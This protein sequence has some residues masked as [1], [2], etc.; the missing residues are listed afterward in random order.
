[1]CIRDRFLALLASAALAGTISAQEKTGLLVV[2]NDADGAKI[3]ETPV[4]IESKIR[5]SESGVEVYTGE[6]LSSTT[7][8][9][10]LSSLKFAYGQGNGIASIAVEKN[11]RL[12]HNPVDDI[13]EP[14]GLQ[15]ESACLS[16]TDLS[17]SIKVT[18]PEWRGE[19]IDVSQLTPGL[20]FVT[21]DKTTLK[22]IKK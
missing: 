9:A 3:T 15:A 7:P 21:I 1:M 2:A 22:F 4:N 5:F 20:Y 19:A 11:L 17:G 12:R 10:G 13:L 16:V 6:T 18:V 8:Y 14:I